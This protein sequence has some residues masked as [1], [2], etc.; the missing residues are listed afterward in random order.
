MGCEVTGR[1][2]EQVE[3]EWLN[4]L[5]LT[6]EQFQVSA[7]KAGVSFDPYISTEPQNTEAHPK[8]NWPY[9]YTYIRMN[10]HICNLSPFFRVAIDWR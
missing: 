9:Y 3:E 4:L 6:H 8:L 7:A 2:D 1:L 10:F 5:G